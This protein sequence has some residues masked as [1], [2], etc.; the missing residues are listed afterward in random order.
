VPVAVTVW[1]RLSRL[2]VT[3]TYWGAG[4]LE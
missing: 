4:A 1:V 2:A 3:V